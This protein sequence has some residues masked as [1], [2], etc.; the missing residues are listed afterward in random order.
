MTNFFLS[1]PPTLVVVKNEGFRK[2]HHAY[3]TLSDALWYN[4]DALRGGLEYEQIYN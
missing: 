1:K 2:K 4:I 3:I